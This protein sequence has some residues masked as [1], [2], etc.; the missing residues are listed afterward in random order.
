M[1]PPV[2]TAVK[3]AGARPAHRLASDFGTHINKAPLSGHPDQGEVTGMTIARITTTLLIAAFALTGFLAISP[4]ATAQANSLD[5]T[6]QLEI[7]PIDA[8]I[9]PLSDLAAIPFTIR[10]S[11]P[12]G[13]VGLIATPIA[14]KVD[15]A[16]PWAAVTISPTTL[17]A[18]TKQDPG[19]TTCN[20]DPVSGRI[21]VSTTADAPAF[22]PANLK[23]TAAAG[24]NGNIKPTSGSES[25]LIRA[26]FFSIIDA[27]PQT[28]IQIATP[29]QQVVYPITI[30]N[31]GNAQT[32]V[33]FEAG[34][35]PESWQV[36]A[37]PP[38]TLDAK[39]AGGKQTSISVP[40]TIQ[41]PFRN[42]YLNEVG[43]AVLKVTSN[44][45]LD[46]TKK[47][48]QTTVTTLTTTKGFY[49]PGFEPLLL[50]GALGGLALL[51]RRKK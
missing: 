3:A 18:G 40:F 16:P 43:A 28:T 4:T 48:D 17:F 11:Y 15:E 30:T 35:R 32:K 38:L 27:V 6:V 42:G 45:A 25:T 7:T 14:M 51:A 26:D 50:V 33:F 36:V 37:P 47:G 29:Q 21:L 2:L 22:T 24:G 8:A 9:K 5:A 10:Y 20:S 23:I 41:T 46:N 19:K 12:C 13:G 49:V 1:A 39:Q 44:Y 31:F 34:D